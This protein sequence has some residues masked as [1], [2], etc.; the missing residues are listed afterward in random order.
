VYGIGAKASQQTRPP[1]ARAQNLRITERFW[2][3]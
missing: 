2:F 3:R 1:N